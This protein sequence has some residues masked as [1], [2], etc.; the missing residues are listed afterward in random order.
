[1]PKGG[2]ILNKGIEVSII[3]LFIVSVVNPMVIGYEAD[4]VSEVAIEIEAE[5]TREIYSDYNQYNKYYY[6]EGYLTGQYPIEEDNNDWSLEVSTLSERNIYKPKQPVLHNGPMNSSWPMYCHDT[7]HTG[8][9]P[10]STVDT[11][12]EIW[13]FETSGWADSSPAIDSNGTIY[14]GSHRFYAINPNGTLKWEFSG[15]SIEA[16]CPAIDDNGIIYVGTHDSGYLYAIYPNGS[17]KWKYRVSGVDSSP[18]IG[19]DGTI[20][21][22]NNKYIKAL[23]LNGTLK[24]S[25]QTGHVIYSSPAIGLDGTVYCGSHDDHVY[26]LYPNGTLKWKYNTGSWV[27]GSPTIGDDGIVYIGSDNGYLY[28][29]YPSNGTVKWEV[30]IGAVYASPALDEDSILYVGVWEKQFYAIYPN[31][32]IKWSFDPGAKIWGSSP[33]LSTD[34]TLY[35]GT[36]NLEWTGGKEI[37]ALYTDGTVKW[38]KKLDTVFSSP[39]IGSDGTVY[40]GSCGEPGEGFLN[41]FGRGELEADANGP[42]FGTPTGTLYFHGDATGGYPPY[43]WHWD[44]GDGNYSIKQNS[45]HKY[46]KLGNY[47]LILTVTDNESNIANDT[48]FVIVKE[49]F[50]PPSPP[51]INGEI[52]GKAGVE[53]EYSFVSKDPELEDITY[54]ILWDDGI[55]DKIYDI[56]SGDIA[57]INHSWDARGV[58]TISAYASTY[59]HHSNWSYLEVTMPKSQ[60]IYLGCLERFPILQQLLLL[61]K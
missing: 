47:T 28:A 7:R 27:H 42:Y 18:T 23:N 20:Y 13:Q 10:Y 34:N 17:L 4:A 60:N 21:F 43:N 38:R 57:Y 61:I 35:F 5:S 22:A 16:T 2:I 50:E 45:S 44:F 48:T 31:G 11:W 36:C 1:V 32:T 24:W 8:R 37:T 25:Y 19:N 9:S 52:N 30:N 53:Y 26:A 33:A 39:A 54:T 59:G 46:S 49:Y 41:A 15:G 51:I 56:P 40:I 12:D 3:V 29:F 55:V 6:P 58:Y 14:I